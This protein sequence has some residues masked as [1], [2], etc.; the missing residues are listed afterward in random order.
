MYINSTPS[1]N[2][3][4]YLRVSDWTTGE[5]CIYWTD[6]R[7]EQVRRSFVSRPAQVACHLL[8]APKG[9][10]LSSTISLDQIAE[11]ISSDE[12]KSLAHE[13]PFLQ[14]YF[15]LSWSHPLIL[16]IKYGRRGIEFVNMD[17]QIK[18]NEAYMIVKGHYDKTIT[19]A[20]WGVVALFW[21][22]VD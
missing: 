16:P 10:T 20:G 15:S 22:V 7:G 13:N 3:R 11:R 8:T 1:D 12:V 4:A 14:Q 18:K 5:T 9:Y 19:E 17:T 21:I 6:E 2:V